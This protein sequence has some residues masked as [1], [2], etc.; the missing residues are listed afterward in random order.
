MASTCLFTFL[1]LWLFLF[2]PL[3][4]LWMMFYMGFTVPWSL[5]GTLASTAGVGLLFKK[6]VL[7]KLASRFLTHNGFVTRWASFAWFV[8]LTMP[9]YALI[10]ILAALFRFV[11]VAVAAFFYMGAVHVTIL[12]PSMAAMFDAAWADSWSM[13]VASHR[14]NSPINYAFARVFVSDGGQKVGHELKST[15]AQ[16]NWKLA[17]TLARNPTLIQS[18]VSTHVEEAEEHQSREEL[19]PVRDAILRA[20]W[21]P[22]LMPPVREPILAGKAN[23]IHL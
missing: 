22:P 19:E 21:D 16:R 14:H 8:M 23:V 1:L 6:V 11:F 18:R 15:R 7:D 10:G 9:F 3:E 12:P 20:S 2:L 4:V 5:V 17:V 13:L